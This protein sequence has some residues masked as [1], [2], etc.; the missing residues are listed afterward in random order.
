MVARVGFRAG[1]SALFDRVMLSTLELGEYLERTDLPY[2]DE[3]SLGSTCDGWAYVV[4]SA[5]ALAGYSPEGYGG[6]VDGVFDAATTSALGAFQQAFGQLPTGTV[7]DATWAALR[8]SV[9]LASATDA[10]AGGGS[11][12]PTADRF[13]ELLL[14]Q[15]GDRYVFGAEVDLDDADPD[16]F[17]CSELIQWATHQLG[18][19]FPDGSWA[20]IA[21]AEEISVD[22]AKSLRGALLWRPGHVAISLGTGNETVEARGSKYGVV[23]YQINDRFEKGGRIPGIVY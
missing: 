19:T 18:V 7:D 6:Q 4:D 23:E 11:D 5:L 21:A 10:A 22:A 14:A 1:G 2:L 12:Q 3:R 13:V 17:D 15:V 16:T 8:Q 9:E 20:Q